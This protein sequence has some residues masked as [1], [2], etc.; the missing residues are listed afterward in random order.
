MQCSENRK[1]R[2]DR[3]M[4]LAG[5][6]FSVVTG[7]APSVVRGQE[8]QPAH[9]EPAADVSHA[10]ADNEDHQRVVDL[11]EKL[12]RQAAEI[13]ALQAQ[14]AHGLGAE[15]KARQEAVDRVT[16]E[17]KAAVESVLQTSP[18]VSGSDGLTLSGFVETDMYVKQS[19]E[20][21][22]NTSTGAP[23]NDN[24]FAIKRARLRGSI[25]RKYLAAIVELDTNTVNGPQARPMT[26]EVTVK[27]PGETVPYVAAT[28][29]IFK[30]PYGFEIGQ[31]DYDR[32]FAERRN[33]ERAMFPGEFDLGARLAGG[34]KY[35]RY[36]LA[37]Q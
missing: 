17:S 15:A 29:G 2:S 4:A 23:L 16:A 5:L 26:T 27:L 7:L 3:R 33:L 13:A 24:R 12:E 25:D 37:V 14:L 11:S 8:S 21:Q 32:L 30:I 9:A 18:K 20:D 36:A 6:L 1:F 22:L 28:V 31:A 19:S 10:P 35:I 34:W